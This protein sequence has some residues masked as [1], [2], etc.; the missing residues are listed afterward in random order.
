MRI[1]GKAEDEQGGWDNVWAPGMSACVGECHTVAYID[2]AGDIHLVGIMI[3]WP[4]FCLE[5]LDDDEESEEKEWKTI[6]LE[7][8]EYEIRRKEME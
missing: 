1:V 2:G 7:G 4:A 5:I 8:V 3:G 6:T